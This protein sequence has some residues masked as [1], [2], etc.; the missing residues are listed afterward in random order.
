[1][2][3]GAIGGNQPTGTIILAGK[4]K[5]KVVDVENEQ[6]EEE[7]NFVDSH[8][9]METE[10]QIKTIT[11]IITTQNEGMGYQTNSQQDN[12]PLQ[13]RLNKYNEGNGTGK[14]QS[15]NNAN[16]TKHTSHTTNI[17]DHN[18]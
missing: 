15:Y 10:E 7:E 16:R 6:D 17:R 8:D 4:R 18:E 1:M 14:P 5:K 13:M 12:E 9:N 2:L 3:V 11:A